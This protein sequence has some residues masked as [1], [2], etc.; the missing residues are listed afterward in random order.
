MELIILL[1]G[2]I[3]LTNNQ[4]LSENELKTIRV[5]W[6]WKTDVDN[7]IPTGEETY[8]ISVTVSAR[9]KIDNI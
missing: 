8:D 1:L 6:E 3:N 9:Q 7:E 2:I 4:Q 5:N